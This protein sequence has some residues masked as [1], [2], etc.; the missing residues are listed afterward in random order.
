MP[1]VNILDVQA[2]GLEKQ[3]C[4]VTLVGF[5]TDR[6]APDLTAKLGS[7]LSREDE[8]SRRKDEAMRGNCRIQA[9]LIGAQRLVQTRSGGS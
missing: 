3:G 9:W 5:D 4:D 6:L 2:Q 7:W 1:L 8:R